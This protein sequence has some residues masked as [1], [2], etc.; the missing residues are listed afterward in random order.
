MRFVVF[1]TIFLLYCY[2]AIAQ[3]EHQNYFDIGKNNV[4]DGV[5]L[6][7]ASVSGYK[8][9]YYQGKTG[10]LF[11]FS[12]QSDRIFTGWFLDGSGSFKIKDIPFEA[13]AFYRI[14][15]FSNLLR[16]INWGIYMSYSSEHF[17]I[18]LGNNFRIYRYSRS[19]I[20]E[21]DIQE[22]PGSRITEPRN[23]MYSIT[24]YI[25]PSGHKWNIASSIRDFDYFLIQQ[26]TNP[27]VMCRF[28]FNVSTHMNIYSEMWYQSAGLFNIQV[29]Y[30][31][32]FLRT[33]LI[34]KIK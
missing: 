11:S 15:P 6:R 10:F 29:N 19:K 27:M 30:F 33:G 31:G 4:S 8:Y 18:R 16:E 32:L 5:F 34:L 24:Y 20:D 2:S 13:G 14:S 22:G 28:H 21:Y 26:E 17:R 1:H 7:F 25:K 23:L 12:N 9:K 3:T